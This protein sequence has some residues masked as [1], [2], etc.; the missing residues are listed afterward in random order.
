M[1]VRVGSDGATPPQRLRSRKQSSPTVLKALMTP[2]RSTSKRQLSLLVLSENSTGNLRCDI[3]MKFL[4]NAQLAV[5][6]GMNMYEWVTIH[7]K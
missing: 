7:K 4:I 1:R 3:H 5:F 6:R 2:R